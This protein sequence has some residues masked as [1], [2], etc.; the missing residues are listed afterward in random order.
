MVLRPVNG[1]RQRDPDEL[2]GCCWVIHYRKIK[3][4]HFRLVYTAMDVEYVYDSAT[5]ER[6]WY[7]NRTPGEW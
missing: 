4:N 1:Y 6:G 2:L 3:S 7:P 5:P